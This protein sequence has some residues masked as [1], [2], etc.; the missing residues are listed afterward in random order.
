MRDVDD[1]AEF[2]H[3]L[4]VEPFGIDAVQ[5]VRLDAAL[6]P[7]RLVLVMGEVEDAAM[8][9]HDVV[10]ELAAE[11]L[12]Q[13]QRVVVDRRAL[14]EEIVGADDGRVAARIAAADPALLDHGDIGDPVFLGE[15]VGG[16]E[17]V[18]AA[19]DDDGVVGGLRLGMR[20][21]RGAQP[22]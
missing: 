6:E 1:R 11:R 7:A 20:A 18:P 22:L 16:R 21:R 15:V 19:A 12:P 5:A 17:P 9:H 10:V 4:G 3:L 2:L 13:V 14:V 8:A